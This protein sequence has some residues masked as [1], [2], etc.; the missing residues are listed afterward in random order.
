MDFGHNRIETGLKL[1]GAESPAPRSKDTAKTEPS[2][3]AP[4]GFTIPVV[5]FG[6]RPANCLQAS[7]FHSFKNTLR[8]QVDR[9]IAF[10]PPAYIPVKIRFGF[11]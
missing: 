8:F 3:V 10:K 4:I 9:L 11:M 5:P 1:G 6:H 7:G 2:L